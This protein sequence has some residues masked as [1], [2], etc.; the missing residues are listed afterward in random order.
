[1]QVVNKVR[2]PNGLAP[3]DMKCVCQLNYYYYWGKKEADDEMIL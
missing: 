1:M 2:I 3:I